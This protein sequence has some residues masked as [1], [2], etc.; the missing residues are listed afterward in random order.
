MGLSRIEINTICRILM[1]PVPV[2]EWVEDC[3][4]PLYGD[5]DGHEDAGGQQD[6]MEGVEEVGEEVVVYLGGKTLDCGSVGSTCLESPSNTFSDAH[7]KEEEIKYCKSNQKIVE[8]ALEC[9]VTKD[10]D[11]KDVGNHPQGGEDDSPVPTHL[12]VYV[13]K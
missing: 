11:G 2:D 6:V 9:L 7:D 12:F 4:V 1:L 5:G 8:V 10:T 3:Q 13:L